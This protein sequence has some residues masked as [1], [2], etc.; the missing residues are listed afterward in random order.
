MDDFNFHKQTSLKDKI[1]LITGGAG[2]I[3]SSLAKAVIELE[4]IPILLDKND[5]GL[6]LLRREFI[7]RN[8]KNEI[9]ALNFL[10]TQAMDE[11]IIDIKKKYKKIDVLINGVAFAM[12]DLQK[13][14]GD[15][16]EN[17]ENYSKDLWQMAID[18]NLTGTFLIT[19]SV[20]KIMKKNGGGKI[21]NIASD[22]GVI[23][24]DHRI[25][26]PNP[27]Y[28]YKGVDFNTPL[29]YSVSKAGIIS[30]T[31]YLA[32]YWAKDGIN[33]NSVSPAGIYNNQD[34][35]FV[36]QLSYRIPLGRM[37]KVQEVVLPIIFLCTDASSF[38][39]GT[40]LMLDGGRTAW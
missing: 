28:D 21:V 14:S 31:K 19:Q 9:Y 6:K 20:G 36:E 24:P 22:V 34:E 15:F 30:M 18:V 11:V 23:S 5:E 32:T 25:Y 13:S 17:F 4:G 26:E 40:N 16:F 12:K 27:F 3:G 37:A 33:V 38:I 7:A 10:N 35:K 29:S 1:V 8:K 2:L 39:T